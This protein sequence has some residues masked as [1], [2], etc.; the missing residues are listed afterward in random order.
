MARSILAAHE[1]VGFFVAHNL[2]GFWIELQ[3]A[4]DA[5]GDVAEVTKAGRKVTD[6][7]VGIRAC[8]G[9][10]AFEEVAVMRGSIGAAAHLLARL[11]ARAEEFEAFAFA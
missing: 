3:R 1:G 8:A 2:L 9:F 5:S 11:I 10:D 6:F 4:S 7:N